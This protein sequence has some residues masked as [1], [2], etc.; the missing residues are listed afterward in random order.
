MNYIRTQR[1][2]IVDFTK[3]LPFVCARIHERVPC[4]GFACEPLVLTPRRK[5]NFFQEVPARAPETVATLI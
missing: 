5:F 3:K 2:K 1:I 4:E